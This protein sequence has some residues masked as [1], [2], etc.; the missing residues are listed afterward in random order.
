[1]NET[2]PLYIKELRNHIDS[3]FSEVD[4]RFN[5]IDD[6]FK[7]VDTRFDK[8]NKKFATKK[9]LKLMQIKFEKHTIDLT[10]GF[11]QSLLGIGDYVKS[12]DEKVTKLDASVVGIN[13]KLTNMQGDIFF[14]RESVKGFAKKNEMLGLKRRIVKLEPH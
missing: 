2:Q 10:S 7:E 4:S 1:M 3:K 12:I 5:K 6:R 14:I 11:Q 9:D 13:N 8:L